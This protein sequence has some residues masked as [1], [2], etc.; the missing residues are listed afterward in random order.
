MSQRENI[1]HDLSL[2]YATARFNDFVKKI[3]DHVQ[4][5]PDDV[6]ELANFYSQAYTELSN[7]QDCLDFLK[8]QSD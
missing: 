5:Y 1:I 3:P 8:D 2:I 7:N 6:I 4:H